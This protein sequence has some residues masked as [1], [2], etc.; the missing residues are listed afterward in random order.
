M[1]LFGKQIKLGLYFLECCL[2][3]YSQNLIVVFSE[4]DVSLFRSIPERKLSPSKDSA[5]RLGAVATQGRYGMGPGQGR[6]ENSSLF[7]EDSIY[8]HNNNRS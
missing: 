4:V 3:V 1:V 8:Y 2:L 7:G 5:N 6:E